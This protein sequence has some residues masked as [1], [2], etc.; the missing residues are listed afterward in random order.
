MSFLLLM[1]LKIKLVAYLFWILRVRSRSMKGQ[2]TLTVL[3]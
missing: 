3:L 1:F 2:S